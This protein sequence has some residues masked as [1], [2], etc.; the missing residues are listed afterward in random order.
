MQRHTRRRAR[1]RRSLAAGRAEHH[2][3]GDRGRS[4]HVH[5]RGHL[6]LRGAL[7]CGCGPD[8]LAPEP[9]TAAPAATTAPAWVPRRRQHT[10]FVRTH[11]IYSDRM[12]GIVR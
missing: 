11:F 5:S 9:R 6:A 2:R 8:A 10:G 3:P 1:S 7:R 12:L 4:D